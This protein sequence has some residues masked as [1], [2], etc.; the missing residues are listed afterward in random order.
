MEEFK[1]GLWLKAVLQPNAVKELIAL[2]IIAC[3]AAVPPGA[4]RI[5]RILM[6]SLLLLLLLVP[7]FLRRNDGKKPDGMSLLR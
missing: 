5:M 7:S 3:P 6:T 4:Y 2:V 1:S